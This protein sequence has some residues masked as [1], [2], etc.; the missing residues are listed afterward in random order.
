MT[1]SERRQIT[2]PQAL[3][4]LA[5]PIRLQVL[6]L[7]TV[8]GP[9]TGRQLADRT[10]ESTASI[11]YHVGQLAKWGLVEPAAEL[12]RGRERP[13][14]ATSRGLTWS[15]TG[16]GEFVAAS[17]ALRDQLISRRLDELEAHRRNEDSLDP[18]W[19]DAAWVGEDAGYLDPGELLEA[20]ERIKA[21]IAEYTDPRRTR[22]ATARRVSFFAYAVPSPDESR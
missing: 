1:A 5:H 3:R 20:A 16:S 7:L 17:R 18:A 11:S 10:G 12:A 2:D 8:D 15:S 19:R 4:A 21:V 9:A 22:S 14:R 6:E 13:W